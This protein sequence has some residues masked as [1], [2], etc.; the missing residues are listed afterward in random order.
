MKSIEWERARWGEQTDSQIARELGCSMRGVQRYRL[1]HQIPATQ[2]RNLA[3]TLADEALVGKTLKQ[4]AAELGVHRVTV[5]RE[6][7]RRGLARPRG[8]VGWEDVDWTKADKEIAA[9]L[10]VR[11]VRVRKKRRTV[12]KMSAKAPSKEAVDAALALPKND[13]TKALRALGFTWAQVAQ[14]VGLSSKQGAARQAAYEPAAKMRQELVERLMQ[15]TADI[16]DAPERARTMKA[17]GAR[18]VEIAR[19]LGVS[20]ST[21]VRWCRAEEPVVRLTVPGNELAP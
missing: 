21:V 12:E 18:T 11:V 19:A 5:G 7:A 9:E 8:K 6:L 17:D 14:M 10:G 15:A 16:T 13:R 20:T 3:K 1:A 4:L 2:K